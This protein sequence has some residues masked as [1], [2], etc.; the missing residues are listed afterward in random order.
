LYL[1]FVP[2]FERGGTTSGGRFLSDKC[3]PLLRGNV[4]SDKGVKIPLGFAVSPF[5]KGELK[6][7]P[8][9]VG[10]PLS[11]KGHNP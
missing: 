4:T 7:P 6:S 9:Q 5:K 11:I 3:F 10:E 8:R 2:L 1:F